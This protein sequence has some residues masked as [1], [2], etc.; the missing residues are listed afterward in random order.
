MREAKTLDR[1]GQGT[2]EDKPKDDEAESGE[3]NTLSPHVHHVENSLAGTCFSKEE[4]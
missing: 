3:S 1:K 2:N 4:A